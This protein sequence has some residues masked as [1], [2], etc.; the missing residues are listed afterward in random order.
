MT[1]KKIL[2]TGASIAGP[3]LAYWL[4]KYGFETTIV[5]RA[6]SLRTGGQNI[7]VK[8]AAQ[9]IAH[10]MGIEDKIRAANTGELGVLFV[11]ANNVPK[12]TL[13]QNDSGSFTSELEILRGDLAKI[14]YNHTKNDVEYIFDN[15]ITIINEIKTGVEVTFKDATQRTFDLV[16]CADGIR[17]STRALILGKQ[18]VVHPL[19]TYMAYFT[20][21]KATTDTKWARWYNAPNKR[22]VFLRPDN[23]GT[24]RASFSFIA[25]PMGYEKLSMPEQKQILQQKFADAGWE[26]TR[27]LAELNKDTTD[28]YFDSISQV[29]APKWFVGRCAITGDAAYCPSP[30]SGMGANSAIIGAYILAGEISK[31]DN[32][33]EAF[34]SYEKIMRPFI[35]DIQKLPP[36]VPY[37]AHPKG[38]MG[39]LFLHL[40]LNFISSKFIKSVSKLFENKNKSP[41]DDKII[42]PNYTSL[43]N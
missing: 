9:K 34:A 39:L 22:V 6:A 29:K 38:K 16:L 35:T 31:N 40:V 10:L 15:Y 17:S 37:I 12:A 8:G 24:T 3:T 13:P 14:L 21:P 28:V 18:N 36:G 7:D 32:H 27:L 42:L 30:F 1:K 4:T 41:Y 26:S 2:I 33:L 20:I 11:D 5:E 25:S 19:N 43:L 23:E